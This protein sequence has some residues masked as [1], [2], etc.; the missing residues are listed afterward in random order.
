M[1]VLLGTC[2]NE[3]L[4]DELFGSVSEFG[5]LLEQSGDNFIIGDIIV[6]YDEDSDIHSFYIEA[7]AKKDHI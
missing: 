1:E 5:R 7:I 2:V 4:V 6:R 3:L